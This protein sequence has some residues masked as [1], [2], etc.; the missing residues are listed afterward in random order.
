MVNSIQKITVHECA[1]PFMEP[2][3]SRVESNR[4]ESS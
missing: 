2:N 3:L 1:I 4:A